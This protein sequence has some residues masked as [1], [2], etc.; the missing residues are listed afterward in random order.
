Q[1][2]PN[3]IVET[4]AGSDVQ[5]NADGVGVAAQFDNPVGVF[6]DASGALFVTEYDGGR[7]RKIA[8]N[9][10]TSTLTAGLVEPFGLLATEDAIYVQTDRDR[11]GIKGPSTGTLWRIALTGGAAEL[12]IDS[13][14]RPRGLARLPDGRMVVSDRSR[15]TISILNL[16]DRSLVPLAGT[17]VPGHVDG[18]GADAQFNEPYGLALLP[19]GNI[20]VADSFNHSIRK[21]TLTGE[22]S[23]FAG[24]GNP[25]MKD[26]PD[27]S[28]ARFDRPVDV[29]IDVAGDTFVSDAD[30][31][32]IRRISSA[33][34]VQTIAGDGT[35][36]YADGVGATARFFGQEQID[37]APDGKTVYVSDGN[38]GNAQA[39]HRIRRIRIP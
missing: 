29:A 27:K 20:L 15:H 6:L 31:H 17:G 11:D 32:R 30:N 39:F 4:V 12:I 37:V 9:G 3:V 10:T 19:D 35:Q 33:G 21:V 8:S 14:G 5:G 34:E 2:A 1:S 23:T 18:P 13:L 38:G 16:A 26:D 7:L 24:D 36:G 25:G 22:V 28:R